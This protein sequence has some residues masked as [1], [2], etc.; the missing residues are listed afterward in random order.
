[1]RRTE[2]LAPEELRA[3]RERKLRS[4]VRHAYDN[5][6]FY[7]RRLDDAGISVGDIA[8]LDDLWKLPVLTKTDL[9]ESGAQL[10]ARNLRDQDIHSAATGGSTGRSTPFVRDN[11]CLDIKHAAESRFTSW[12]GWDIGK[13][14]A[15]YW[16][17]L[18][19]MAVQARATDGL[20]R[21]FLTRRLAI[22]AGSLNPEGMAEHAARLKRFR[23]VVIR[24]FPS[25]LATFAG[26][27]EG[28]DHGIHPRGIVT[29][30]EPLL[31]NQRKLISSVFG[32]EVY[33]CYVNRE[34]GN[35]ACECENHDGLHVNAECVHVEFDLNGRPA[36][37]G[38]VGRILLTD[39]ENYGMPFIR[40]EVGDMAGPLEGPCSCGRTSPRMTPVVGRVSDFL[41]SPKDGSLISGLVLC[42]YI[43]AEG[44]DVGQ[45]QLIQDRIDHLTVKVRKSDAEAA[46]VDLAHL[47]SV[48]D[49]VFSGAMKVTVDFV[50][51][52]PSEPGGKYRFAVSHVS[53]AGKAPKTGA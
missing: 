25:P 12:A 28:S 13:K 8:G 52:I 50:D 49:R 1:L 44:P 41:T 19:D 15:F 45:I 30:G 53:P 29:V 22:A 5:S 11:A 35:I 27:L 26:F 20:R 17:A 10:R 51:V 47:R 38:D 33:D 34:C 24:A 42:H 6:P 46:V 48:I 37:P 32:C 7:K 16:P 36:K 18:Q 21:T 2:R 23:P 4:L 31:E 9:V 39:F 14:L 43:L 3:I 40:Y